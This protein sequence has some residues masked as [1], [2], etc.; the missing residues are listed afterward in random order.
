MMSLIRPPRRTMVITFRDAM[1]PVGDKDFNDVVAIINYSPV[2]SWTPPNVILPNPVHR[3]SP[4]SQMVLIKP[5][6]IIKSLPVISKI[7]SIRRNFD[8]F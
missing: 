4:S 6:S 5:D 8:S 7:I 3:L 1:T 2:F